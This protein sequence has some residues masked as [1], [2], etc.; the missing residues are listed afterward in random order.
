MDSRLLNVM[1]YRLTLMNRSLHNKLKELE[2]QVQLHEGF[3]EELK[4]AVKYSTTD[5]LH[6]ENSMVPD[7]TTIV[8]QQES[9]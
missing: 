1:L 2:L 5:F 6:L 7:T 4:E 9:C 8:Q 3:I